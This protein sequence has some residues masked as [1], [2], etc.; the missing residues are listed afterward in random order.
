MST[1]L[2]EVNKINLINIQPTT[3]YIDKNGPSTNPEY[4]VKKVDLD[5]QLSNIPTNDTVVSISK[6]L[7]TNALDNYYDKDHIDGQLSCKSNTNHTHTTINN[8]LTINSNGLKLYSSK[9]AY[10][11]FTF[12]KNGKDRES[13]V[14]GFGD[15][16]MGK[17]AFIRV[18]GGKQLTIFNDKATFPSEF[19]VTTLNGINP[20]TISLNTHNHD[21]KYALVD[22]THT[23]ND[24][25]DIDT[26]AKADHNHDEI[27]SKLEH[28]HTTS[29]I[30]DIDTLAKADHNHDETYSKLEHTHAVS[31]IT[32]VSTLAKTDHNHDGVY[33][34]LG[35]MHTFDESRENFKVAES[36]SIYRAY[37]YGSSDNN[38]REWLFITA[39]KGTKEYLRLY[40]GGLYLCYFENCD[41][42]INLLNTTITHNAPLE[43]SLDNYVI[44]KP[45]F[46]SGN[47]YKL[48][49]G[50]YVD[51]TDTT[52]CIPSV[53]AEGK[54]KEYLG[55]VVAKHK[56]GETV[57]V[58]DIVKHDVI[59]GQDTIDFATH[60]DFYLK[61]NDSW[62]YQVGDT[63]L[64]NG[65]IVNDE[66]PMTNKIQRMIAGVVT[67]I[68]DPGTLAIF[69]A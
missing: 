58:G 8:A 46:I 7:I 20:S 52:D 29:D 23:T 50:K 43:E 56:A 51:R 18:N 33:S 4:Y 53:K 36:F 25:T 26:L 57:T 38:T 32:D 47:V 6:N 30:T 16:N 3:K 27:Y 19:T 55:I 24:I 60:G 15:D 34:K 62:P 35:H 49:E 40:F 63:V 5:K 2:S 28:T 1:S 12:G 9:A 37:N 22:H 45:V 10:T 59:I 39:Y 41:D 11:Y 64:Y 69:K 66:G 44:G 65:D 67:A 54:Y 61:V 42:D 17:Y 21:D 68:V 14:L 31:D 48:K 13:A